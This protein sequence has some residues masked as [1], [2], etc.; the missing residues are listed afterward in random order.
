MSNEVSMGEVDRSAEEPKFRAQAR[1]NPQPALRGR[2]EPTEDET[3]A[4]KGFR[5][6][7]VVMNAADIDAMLAA[8]R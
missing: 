5:E 8:S 3:K 7:T 6:L 1:R 2:L 4:V